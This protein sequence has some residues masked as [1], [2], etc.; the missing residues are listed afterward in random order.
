MHFLPGNFLSR[1]AGLVMKTA[2]FCVAVGVCNTAI[3]NSRTAQLEA[4]TRQSLPA[5]SVVSSKN[6]S[7][8][9]NPARAWREELQRSGVLDSR[10]PFQLGLPLAAFGDKGPRLM[11]TYVPRMRDDT[12]TRV[13]LFYLRMNLD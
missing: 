5:I 1:I 4:E 2:P 11:F 9:A 8:V 12:A 7:D 13:F 10:G 3:A 6:D